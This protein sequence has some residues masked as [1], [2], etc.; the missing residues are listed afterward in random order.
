[1][2]CLIQDQQHLT[3]VYGGWE[4]S[5][6]VALDSCNVEIFKDYN[7]L[8]VHAVPNN[9]FTVL[10]IYSSLFFTPRMLRRWWILESRRTFVTTC[11]A[12]ASSQNTPTVYPAGHIL[13]IA[14]INKLRKLILWSSVLRHLYWCLCFGS[15]LVWEFVLQRHFMHEFWVFMAP[16]KILVFKKYLQLTK[17]VSRCVCVCVCV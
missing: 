3:T 7:P 17:I 13:H 10:F 14:D 9:V 2:P 16:Y 11:Q 5:R 1:M 12:C 4:C 6:L 8:L 15:G